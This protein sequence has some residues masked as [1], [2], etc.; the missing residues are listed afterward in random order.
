MPPAQPPPPTSVRRFPWPLLAAVVLGATLLAAYA[1]SFRVPFIFDDASSIAENLTLRS[2]R[3]AFLPPGDSGLT[4]SGRPLLNATLAFNYA[5][6]RENVLGY[7]VTNLAIHFLA[8]LTLFSLTRRTLQLPSFPQLSPLSSPLHSAAAPL[9]LAV[10]ALWALHPLQT[11]SVTYVVQRAESLVGLFYLLTLYCFLRSIDTPASTRRWQIATFLSCL[12][13]MASKEVM[14]SAPLVVFLFDRTFVA[15]SFAEAW[16]SRRRL[17]LALASTWILL[18]ACII[19]TGNRGGTVGT[20][21]VIG[22][23]TYFVTQCHALTHYLRLTFWPHPLVLDYGTGVIDNFA[24]VLGRFVFL[25]S[26]GLA[27]LWALWKRPALGFLGVVFFAVL[28]PTSSFVP[29]TTQTMA[30]HRMYLALVP[31]ATLFALGLYSLIGRP[32]LVLCLLIT[33]STGFIT[34]RRNQDYRS[35]FVIWE[36][37]LVKAPLNTRAFVS[38]AALHL[39]ADD[40][41][42]AERIITRALA[43]APQDPSALVTY[44]NVLAEQAR[45]EESF[46][47]FERALSSGADFFDARYNYGKA[48]LDHGSIPQAI[49][50]L[51]RAIALKS[52]SAD[53][54]YNLGNA[55]MAAKRF[56]DAVAQYETVLSID[57]HSFDARSNR[58]NALISLGRVPE[59]LAEYEKALRDAPNNSRIL[60]N[61]GRAL[62]L[63]GRG[64]E[65]IP[66]FEQAVTSQP[67]LPEARANLATALFARGRT[68]EAIPHFEAAIA[69]GLNP[70]EL[71]TTFG[72]ALL[73]AGRIE[74]AMSQLQKALAQSPQLAEARYALANLLLKTS[75]PSDAVPHYISLLQVAPNAHEIHNNLGI[76]Y[77]QLGRMTEARVC[78]EQAVRLRPDFT[79]AQENLERTRRE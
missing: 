15:G 76:A 12:A 56:S 53:A 51:E 41:N 62:G 38:L 1:N 19:S 47:S 46:A 79:D 4:V 71:R 2:W 26:L 34:F 20:N 11:E 18:A 3:T 49:V 10:S 77:A 30:E 48:L 6:S 73:D 60:L 69:L 16:R 70:P 44:G 24:E 37:T 8:A 65:V 31:L 66:Y 35:A 32:A 14:A 64:S 57:P 39:K 45:F 22:P 42:A 67:D 36:D 40:A 78:F 9:A 61:L 7:H 28:A 59:A 5:L 43:V 63:L 54:H 13:G 75:R 52:S 17:H 27:T 68:T 23:W 72:Q 58:G 50:Q 33:L 21:E 25:V 74:E 55:Y 29:I